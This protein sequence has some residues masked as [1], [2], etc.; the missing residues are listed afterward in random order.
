MSFFYL[1]FNI[2]TTINLVLLF[3]FLFFRKNNSITNKLLGLIILNPGLNFINN[4][5]IQ[6]GYIDKFPISLFLFYG[7]GQFYGMLMLAYS[8]LMI[9]EKYRWNTFLNY[10]TFMIVL[11]DIY[12]GIEFAFLPAAQKHTYLAGLTDVE[13]FP[14][15]M[16]VINILFT[17]NLILHLLVIFIKTY[18]RSRLAKNY[19]SDFENIKLRYVQVFV[20]I[21]LSLS[22][23]LL[24]CYIA[25]STP[26]VE[27]FFIPLFI[28]AVYIFVLY[29]AFKHSAILTSEGYCN[30]VDVNKPL[31]T[32]KQYAEPLCQEIKQ[33]KEAG[34]KGKY[35]LT[36]LEID[37]NY[38]HL[39]SYF[40]DY[41][42]FL[43]PQINLTKLSADLNAC[44]HNISLTINMRFNM[45]FFDL[46]NSYRIKEAKMMLADVNNRNL[47]I[48]AIG[49]ECGFNTKSAFYR[50][51][52]KHTDLTPTEYIQ[53]LK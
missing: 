33:M 28:N 16:N 53:S 39:L 38:K 17:I 30:L 32:Y 48:E 21:N 23:M 45:N 26:L 4:I 27:Y 15:Q 7:T 5:V 24:I 6:S 11:L 51:F 8:Q 3:I 42:P 41:K 22:I 36:E 29:Y 20:G 18:Q 19:F 35:K 43:D 47:T 44:S 31:E 46:I 50:A 52:K 14:I 1:Y 49:Q 34:V 2:F 37:E 10:F 40:N 12:W 25:F 13:H 9:G